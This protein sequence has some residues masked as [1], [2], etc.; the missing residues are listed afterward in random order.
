[1]QRSGHPGRTCRKKVFRNVFVDML[2]AA[3]AA[4]MEE[5]VKSV[6]RSLFVTIAGLVPARVVDICNRSSGGG[7]FTGIRGCENLSL[8]YPSLKTPWIRGMDPEVK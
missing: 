3:I 1:M 4:I 5:R 6:F 2:R 7:G 8:I